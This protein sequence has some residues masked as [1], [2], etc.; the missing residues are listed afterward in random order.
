[1]CVIVRQPVVEPMQRKVITLDINQSQSLH[2]SEHA[3]KPHFSTAKTNNG[4]E[5]FFVYSILCFTVMFKI[6]I[7]VVCIFGA[8]DCVVLLSRHCLES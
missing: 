1:M 3:W 6:S 4:E 5:V 2:R 8:N 7:M